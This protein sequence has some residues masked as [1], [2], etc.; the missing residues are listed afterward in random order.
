M[1]LA[2]GKGSDAP[3]PGLRMTGLLASVRS[4]DEARTAMQSYADVIDCKNPHQ[5]ALGALPL[6][7]ITRIVE[8]INGERPVSATTGDLTIGT[9]QLREAVISTAECGVDYVKFG[10]FDL[11]S[12]VAQI[13]GLSRIASEH[14]LIA[15]CFADRYDPSSLL[16]YLAGSGVQGV[17]IDT[18]DKRSGRLTGLWSTP[19]I[20]GFVES[21]HAHGLL[22][23]LAGRLEDA[24]IPELLP[25]R[26]DYLGFRSALCIGD[27]AGCLDH[28]R[29]MRVREAIPWRIGIPA[30]GRARLALH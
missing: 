23:G 16:P 2:D 29:M 18:A 19:R 8:T 17:M 20:A 24:D 3:E 6:D 1:G 21:V 4:V 28:V 27:R 26:A 13:N 12:A 11:E 7:T 22:C 14:D 9:R 15:V 25:L 5:G 10:L 30:F